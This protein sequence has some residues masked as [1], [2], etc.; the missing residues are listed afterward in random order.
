MVLGVGAADRLHKDGLRTG[1][2]KGG[3]PHANGAVYGRGV[4]CSPNCSVAAMYALPPPSPG[5]GCRCERRFQV[6]FQ[7]R[8]RGPARSTYGKPKAV[9]AGAT[10]SN[11]IQSG[12]E[13]HDGVLGR[14]E[15]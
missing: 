4:Y 15:G 11:R 6:V 14:A 10:M 5:R 13:P 9:A 3:P 8:V 12:A 7:C 2:S 1:G